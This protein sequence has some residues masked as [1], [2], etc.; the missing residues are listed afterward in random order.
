[1]RSLL[2]FNADFRVRCCSVSDHEAK[3]DKE[4]KGVSEEGALR[5]LLTSDEEEE[6]NEE[7]KNKE[8]NKSD[9]DELPPAEENAVATPSSSKKKKK[10]TSP[11]P[12]KTG[13]GDN[14]NKD[15]KRYENDVSRFYIGVLYS[16]PVNQK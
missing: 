13:S 8:G 4:M 16:V 9:Q 12:V 14:P 6:E 11:S 2:K 15:G 7:E 5:K 10:K 3:I 1:M